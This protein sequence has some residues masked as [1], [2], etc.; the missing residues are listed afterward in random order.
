MVKVDTVS[1]GK[2][3]IISLLILLLPFSLELPIR[4][5]ASQGTIVAHD[6]TVDTVWTPDG[7][8]Y[9][10][11]SDITILANLT[12]EPG[13]VVEVVG[14]T[15]ITVTGS[16]LVHGLPDNPVVFKVTGSGRGWYLNI[17]HGVA[18]IEN[19]VLNCGIVIASTG[20]RVALR[21]INAVMIQ[22]HNIVDSAIDIANG[23]ID[24]LLFSPAYDT[25]P[26]PSYTPSLKDTTMS[27]E[28]VVITHFIGGGYSPGTTSFTWDTC[29]LDTRYFGETG[30]DY[31]IQGILVPYLRDSKLYLRNAIVLGGIAFNMYNASILLDHVVTREILGYQV[32]DSNIT[33]QNSIIAWGRGV[34]IYSIESLGNSSNLTMRDTMIYDTEL[35]FS[36]ISTWRDIGVRIETTTS[37]VVVDLR[38]NWWGDLGGPKNVGGGGVEVQVGGGASLQLYPWLTE[39]PI[40]L[41]DIEVSVNTVP[42]IAVED[43]NTSI[44]VLPVLDNAYYVFLVEE[45]LIS[46]PP[47]ALYTVSRSNSINIVF[48]A[49]NPLYIYNRTVTAIVYYRGVLVGART[50][51]TVIPELSAEI[52]IISPLQ[53]YIGANNVSFEASISTYPILLPYLNVSL[54]LNDTFYLMQYKGDGAYST[55]LILNDGVYSWTITID[56]YGQ[57]VAEV[58]SEILII[59]TE[60]PIVNVS[61][62]PR[63]DIIEVYISAYDR[64]SG[65]KSIKVTGD[66]AVLVYEILDQPRHAINKT[67]EILVENRSI[68]LIVEAI[69]WAGNTYY[70]NTTIRYT[71]AENTTEA[72]QTQTTAM[73]EEQTSPKPG[74]ETEQQTKGASET[75]ATPSEALVPGLFP[76]ILL[77]IIALVILAIIIVFSKR[78]HKTQREHSTKQQKRQQVKNE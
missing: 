75:T 26:W 2:I 49:G 55:D 50:N 73:E 9:I 52:T 65:I 78:R 41:P 32:Y 54:I 34:C 56:Y 31:P 61:W 25:S 10:V 60:P 62:N 58:S 44:E 45:P 23:T 51:V 3:C 11:T 38:S 76:W 53:E 47:K 36:G 8:P 19:T 68:S 6:I 43:M 18:Y 24:Y 74:K 69:D 15:W 77:V 7:S 28:D 14:G 57:H 30:Y 5:D 17:D 48:N 20:G 22:F 46:Y 13:V 70:K 66:G 37:N 16:I 33:I 71:L 63:G 35:F 12:I 64:V 29:Y 4:V 59:D 42:P 67:L 39:P 1:L 21:N 40:P 72:N 27:I